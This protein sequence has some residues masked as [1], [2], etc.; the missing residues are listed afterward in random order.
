MKAI[1]KST[2]RSFKSNWLRFILISSIIMASLILSCGLGSSPSAIKKSYFNTLKS[3]DISD[4]II[5]STNELGFSND[6]INIFEDK[7]K[8]P[9]INIYTTFD[10]VNDEENPESNFTRYYFYPFQNL[11]DNQ[12]INMDNNKMKLIEGR[13]PLNGKEIVVEEGG[14]SRIKWNIGDIFTPKIS[15]YNVELKVVGIVKNPLYS[16]TLK[17]PSIIDTNRYVDTIA[18]FDTNYAIGDL[19]I[20]IGNITIPLINNLLPKNEVSIEYFY[21]FENLTSSNYIKKVREKINVLMRTHLVE[22]ND[23]AYLS[24]SENVGVASFKEYINKIIIISF[25]FPTLFILICSLVVSISFSKY[26]KDER[27][28]IA[29]C[30]SLGIPLNKIA[31]KYYIFALISVLFG[32]LTGLIVGLFLVPTVVFPAFNVIFFMNKL[33]Y[34]FDILIGALSLTF[35]I[36]LSLIIVHLIL[37]DNFKEKPAELLTHPSPKP[38]KKIILER[39]GFLWKPLSFKIKSSIRNISRYK[40]NSILI[41]I[42]NLGSSFLLFLGFGLLD[43]SFK[44]NDDPVFNNIAEPMKIIALVITLIS[45]LLSSLIVFNLINMNISQRRR[46]LATLKVLGYKDIECSLYT[47]RE[48]F[49]LATVGSFLGVPIGHIV[50]DFVLRWLEF[51]SINFVNWYSYIIPFLIIVIL[52]VLVNFLIYPRI[53]KIDMNESL[54]TID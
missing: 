54:K 6:E 9:N 46:E 43:N 17:E 39:I 41:L 12:I 31:K 2:L 3:M 40:K 48:I 32:G 24:L 1:N 11:S 20:K 7:S 45:M 16:S 22:F 30:V 50:L 15:N 10:I 25:I 8:F 33:L 28:Y 53:V 49:S 18:Y 38:G 47:F 51:G 35:L 5:K 42:S 44:M 14:G 26:V 4:V 36:I 23:L 27:N 34:S 19:F 21:G 52:T 13:L 37:K 29:C